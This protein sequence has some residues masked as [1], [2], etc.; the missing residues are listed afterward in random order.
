ML[1]LEGKHIITTCASEKAERLHK[2]LSDQGATVYNYSMISMKPVDSK[3]IEKEPFFDLTN[4]DWIIFTSS[5]GVKYFFYWLN[6]LKIASKSIK[7]KFAVIGSSTQK[8]LLKNNCIANYIGKSKDSKDFALEFSEN[9]ESNQQILWATGNL[10]MNNI[11]DS[12]NENHQ[13]KKL[14]AYETN[15]INEFNQELINQVNQS[16]NLIGIFLS[17]SAVNGF[18]NA[19][20]NSVDYNK[21]SFI[22][23]GKTTANALKEH[24][25]EP[26]FIPSIPNI[27]T[28]VNE[29]NNFYN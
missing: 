28:L 26:L 11:T 29:L 13:V 18:Y 12:L 8:E 19:T 1:G 7:N 24:N 6:K 3:N 2:L 17:P 16:D 9:L 4:Y 23:I 22:P 27:D 5:N 14:I 21:I 20:K 10:A 15:I 25:Q